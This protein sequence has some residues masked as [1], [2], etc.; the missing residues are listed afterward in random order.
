ME[1]EFFDVE[2]TKKVA[3][4]AMGSALTAFF[5]GA[6]LLVLP[7]SPYV[8]IV[9]QVIALVVGISAIRTLNHHEA[10]VIGGV[11]HLGIVLAALG[12]V[13]AVVGGVLRVLVILA[14]H[15]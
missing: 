10:R 12:S 14:V 7:F 6:A 9:F 11:R 1:D 4:R 8:V 15:A 2:A 3:M 5:A 13:A